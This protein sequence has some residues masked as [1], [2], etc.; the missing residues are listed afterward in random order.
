MRV[1]IKLA[2]VGLSILSAIAVGFGISTNASHIDY[3]RDCD[4]FAVI[5]CGTMSVSELR[6]EYASLGTHNNGSTRKQSDIPAVFSA[7][8]I[9]RS[10]LSGSFHS[11]VVY[12]NGIVKV[13]QGLEK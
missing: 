6:A 8:G 10:D 2:L 4:K 1:N 13:N 7:L 5:R 3:S 9:S 11:G 12:K